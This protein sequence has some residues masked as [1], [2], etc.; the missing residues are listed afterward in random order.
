MRDVADLVGYCL[1]YEFEDI[2][3]EITGAD[4]VMPGPAWA[5]SEIQQRLYKATSRLSKS[6]AIAAPLLTALPRLR[7]ERTYDLF[8]AMFNRPQELVALNALPNWRARSRFAACYVHEVWESQFR[9]EMMALLARFDRLYVGTAHAVNT[10]ARQT[11]RPCSYLPCGVDAHKFSPI[12]GSPPR[13][14]DVCYIGRRSEITHQAVLQT[15]AQ[16]SLFYYYDTVR[17]SAVAAADRQ[18]TFR[19]SNPTEHRLL[20]S[21]LLKRSRYFIV[22]RAR[23]NEPTVANGSEE[24]AARLFEGAAAGTVMIGDP[25]QTAEFRELFDWPDAV[26]PAPF[27]AP[28]IGE[29]IA[30]LDADPERVARVRKEGVTNTL[31][32]HDWAYRLRT[33]LGDAGVPLP[34]PLLERE[35]RLR[36]TS[37]EVAA[38]RLM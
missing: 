6:L 14:I 2:I 7:F 37:E 22:N 12:P 8:L 1:E 25:P 4:R 24:I 3:A 20:Y 15:A 32:R 23:A 13:S 38:A 27:H 26:I 28:R 9:M 33:I 10:L 35:A 31:L 18:I 19:V 29:L 21:N 36:A 11:G 17:S 34:P 5:E 16:R 30:E